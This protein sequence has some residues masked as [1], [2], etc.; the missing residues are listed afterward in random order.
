MS[1]IYVN[2]IDEDS[3]EGGSASEGDY[4]SEESNGLRNAS[5]VVAP[6]FPEPIVIVPTKTPKKR[7]RPPKAVTEARLSALYHGAST[8]DSKGSN[9]TP[10]S[11][12]GAQ[13]T[14]TP[15]KRGRPRKAESE[16][17][18]RQKSLLR[19]N[20]GPK[21][22]IRKIEA[23]SPNEESPFPLVQQAVKTD[24][25]KKSRGRPRIHP[26]KD[27]S[28]KRPRGRPR[29]NPLPHGEKSYKS[30]YMR[31][32]RECAKKDTLIE[33]LTQYLADLG[34]SVDDVLR[35]P[36]NNSQSNDDSE[37]KSRADESAAEEE[38]TQMIEVNNIEHSNQ[39][40]IG[41]FVEDNDNKDKDDEESD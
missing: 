39:K 8:I 36:D 28:Q 18:N 16:K 34:H 21:S 12:D 6:S 20:I 38:V 32:K 22:K 3:D 5:T 15:K 17:N 1:H 30:E 31:M 23:S 35:Q 37:E 2:L 26:P 19:I 40:Y 11:F 4:R 25:V 27:P 10:G 7:G 13:A 24:S 29:V 33:R 14:P 9:G 41:M